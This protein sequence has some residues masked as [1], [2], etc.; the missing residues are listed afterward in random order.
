ND[1]IQYLLAV[2]RVND[3][4]AH[5]Y[6]PNH[7]AVIR[8]LDQI[9]SAA[10]K[11]KVTVSVCGE[12]AGDPVYVPLLFGLG[13]DEISATASS[14]PEIKYML[15]Q[16]KLKDA[17]ALAKKVVKLNDPEEIYM[18]LSA[19]YAKLMGDVLKG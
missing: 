18:T 5:L 9:M 14:L 13:A 11:H 3:R 17:Q 2:D 6:Q 8:M 4:I 19:F 15:R 16:M 1:L 7:P 10:R 12:M